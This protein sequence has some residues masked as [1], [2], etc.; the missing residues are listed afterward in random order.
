LRAVLGIDAAWTFE[1]PSGVA[2]V[3]EDA[4]GWHLVAAEPSYQ[5]FIARGAHEDPPERANGC[6]PDASELLTAAGKLS[7]HSVELIA[8]D[9]PVANVP[10]DGRRYAD[11][12]V[13]RAYGARKCGTHSPSANRPGTISKLIREGFLREG[14]PLVT[15]VPVQRGIIEVYPHPAIVELTG[16]ACRL[17]Y[18]IT[19]VKS[20]WKKEN[21]PAAA[22]R[23]RLFAQWQR[24]IDALDRE[25]R[26]VRHN[27]LPLPECAT[28]RQLKA[29]EDVIDAI[30]C[31]WVGTC[32]LAGQIQPPY[33]DQTSAIWIPKSVTQRSGGGD[34]PKYEGITLSRPP[35][36]R[37]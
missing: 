17:P 34:M 36:P 24:I 26:G 7:N 16:A 5:H 4:S 15:S 10:V 33:G 3:A 30:V 21:L 13:S 27:M 18:K 37:G 22:A 2:L 8:V 31:A 20:Y 25:I 9:I 6:A 11:N 12:A 14:Y 19:R 1:E 23:H 32:A 28:R 35:R 29:R